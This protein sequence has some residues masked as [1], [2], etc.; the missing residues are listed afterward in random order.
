MSRLHLRLQIAALIAT[1]LAFVVLALL[2]PGVLLL[3]PGAA[4]A[5]LV[6]S[7]WTWPLASFLAAV[8][9]A[10][11]MR[12]FGPTLK[13]LEQGD[14]DVPG[15]DAAFVRSLNALPLMWVLQIALQTVAVSSLT[16]FPPLRASLIDEPTQGSLVLL[17]ATVV[18][19]V[20][21]PQYV[22]ARALVGQ[23]VESV[24]IRVMETAFRETF[25]SQEDA[26]LEGVAITL[27]TRISR[28]FRARAHSR[29]SGRLAN[30]VAL[31]VAI[32]AFGAALLVNA[33]VRAFEARHRRD[34][35]YG[36]ARGVLEPEGASGANGR[37]A[38]MRAAEELGYQVTV[39]TEG[40]ID[41]ETTGATVG[42]GGVR[43]LRTRLEDGM[44]FVRFA[45]TSASS[46]A[47]GG[48]DVML[49]VVAIAIA[50]AAVMGRSIGRAVARDLSSASREVRLLG[51][52][53]VLRGATRVA[54]PA[55]FRE[56]AAL[57]SGVEEVAARFREF[58]QGRERMIE[59]RESAQRMR[60][61]FLASMSHDLR[62]PLNGILGFVALLQKLQLRDAQQESLAIIDRRGRELLELIENILDAA[63]SEAGRLELARDW[64]AA[65]EILAFAVRRG[66][67]LA[68]EKQ[69]AAGAGAGVVE[70]RGELQH[71]LPPLWV[72]GPRLTQAVI[73]LV[74]NA[75]KYCDRGVVRV[76][77]ARASRGEGRERREGL[78]IDVEDQGRGIPEKE[79]A[80][81]FDAFRQ[82]IRSRRHGGLG[83]GLSM[84]RALVELH[85][86]TID[87]ASSPERGSVFTL[88]VPFERPDHD[89][90]A[91]SGRGLWRMPTP[92][93]GSRPPFEIYDEGWQQADLPSEHRRAVA[94]AVHE[95]PTVQMPPLEIEPEE[96]TDDDLLET[97]E[98]PARNK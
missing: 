30:A 35:A 60:D 26:L 53:D 24:P 70:V 78:R 18:A 94:R 74:A 90:P 45:P 33:H 32:V 86:G 75:V 54:G 79:L 48:V 91:P 66:R 25:H 31:A 37:E 80:Q 10:L 71:G 15:V 72:D 76:R 81:I 40:P 56:V 51:T 20:A 85:G 5:A 97:T 82:P 27:R 8:S 64:T 34:D 3:E 23:V 57:G 61:L 98:W 50:L 16:L 9:T 92:V 77:F 69:G 39:Q 88:F 46:G 62:S 58:A 6:E 2:A 43:T 49:G 4:T 63:K 19:A 41:S 38:A 11:K 28:W 52:A 17:T 87:V 93:P 84:T 44:A 68:L 22:A 96:L 29:V 89:A 13:A 47:A 95:D 7:A 59:A 1:F 42:E 55:R 21:L 14:G 67:E 36:L 65:S 83:L 73:N 12:R